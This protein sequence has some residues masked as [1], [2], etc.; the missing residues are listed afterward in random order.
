[1][2]REAGYNADLPE[3]RILAL[4]PVLQKVISRVRNPTARVI[5]R[6]I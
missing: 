5:V 2:E 3:A 6:L 4:R 1:V